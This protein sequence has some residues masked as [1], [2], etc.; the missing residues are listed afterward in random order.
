VFAR[1]A[2]RLDADIR[3]APVVVITGLRRVYASS[4]SAIA[5]IVC[6]V[7]T[8]V[9]GLLVVETLAIRPPTFV[10]RAWI[11]IVAVLRP[12]LAETGELLEIDV[13]ARVP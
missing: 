6:A 2:C 4:A 10:P 1:S 3:R 13:D 12:V 5:A 9:A 7:Q 11:M 8:I